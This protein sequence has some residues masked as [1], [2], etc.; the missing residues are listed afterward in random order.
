MDQLTFRQLRKVRRQVAAAF[1]A[2]SKAIMTLRT[3][4]FPSFFTFR[5]LQVSHFQCLQYDYAK[6]LELLRQRTER[7]AAESSNFYA[8][9]MH[10]CAYTLSAKSKRFPTKICASQQGRTLLAREEGLREGLCRRRSSS[11]LSTTKN[12]R[13]FGHFRLFDHLKSRWGWGSQLPT[14]SPNLGLSNL[15]GGSQTGGTAAVAAARR[16]PP[17]LRNL[18]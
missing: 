1:S 9:C 3:E 2:F 5:F 18:S 13:I 8:W 16:E 7:Q 6:L 11:G 12:C 14:Q 15:L 17:R 4:I 10:I